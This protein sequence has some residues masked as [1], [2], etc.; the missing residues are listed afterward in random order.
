[1]FAAI[2]K[3]TTIFIKTIFKNS[4]KLKRIR[5]YVPKWNLLSVFFDIGKF[6][7]SGHY[8]VCHVI[9]IFLIFFR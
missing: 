5:N 6:F 3:I 1:M 8:E 2:V 7:Y 4:K 9:H